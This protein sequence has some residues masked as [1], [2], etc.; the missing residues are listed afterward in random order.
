MKTSAFTKS[1][2]P[3]HLSGFS[4][5]VFCYGAGE[6]QESFGNRAKRVL[7]IPHFRQ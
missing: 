4:D 6:S 5:G 1:K 7:A 3:E 2:I